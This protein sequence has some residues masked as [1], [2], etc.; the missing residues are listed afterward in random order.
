MPIWLLTSWKWI[1]SMPHWL[2]GVLLTVLALA[3]MYF[4]MRGAEKKAAT[5]TGKA[6]VAKMKAST[7]KN[8]AR[9]EVQLERIDTLAKER[10][11]I[12]DATADEIA[13]IEDMDDTELSAWLKADA[14]RRSA[15]KHK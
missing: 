11:E 12:R 2:W 1:K 10:T 3:A 8:D 7:A 6:V 15:G 5:A 14:A 13:H 4:R 9:I